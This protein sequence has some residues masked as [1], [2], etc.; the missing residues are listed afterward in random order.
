[1][2]DISISLDR[3]QPHNNY[4]AKTIHTYTNIHH[5]LQPGTHSQSQI[6]RRTRSEWGSKWH[7]WDLKL[8]SFKWKFDTLPLCPWW[9]WTMAWRYLPC[10]LCHCHCQT[11][12]G[13]ET[14][15]PP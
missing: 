13:S 6:T 8:I 14:A 5:G 15:V 10:V 11:T 7:V 9:G 1:M 3:I 12:R 2:A 4:Y